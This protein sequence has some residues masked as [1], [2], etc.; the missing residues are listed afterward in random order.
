MKE[1]IAARSVYSWF[2]KEQP[3][4]STSKSRK[5]EQ[6]LFT[7]YLTASVML[8]LILRCILSETNCS[9][10]LPEDSFHAQTLNLES[11]HSLVLKEPE[12]DLA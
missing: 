7:K 12:N 3:K 8:L 2:T 1:K 9:H 11:K 4:K 10:H 6:S 5:Q